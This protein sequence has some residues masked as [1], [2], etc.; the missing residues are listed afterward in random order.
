MVGLT[1]M[2]L[3]AMGRKNT[4]VSIKRNWLGASRDTLVKMGK[5]GD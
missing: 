3:G 1:Y 5:L 2:A 4:F